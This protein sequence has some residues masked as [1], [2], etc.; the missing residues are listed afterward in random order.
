MHLFVERSS[1]I[2]R[3]SVMT[4]PSRYTSSVRFDVGTPGGDAVVGGSLTSSRNSLSA[5]TSPLSPGPKQITCYVSSPDN[6]DDNTPGLISK[7]SPVEYSQQ[8]QN[9]VP[10]MCRAV[11]VPAILQRD[12]DVE[13]SRSSSDS[14]GRL[15]RLCSSN[16]IKLTLFQPTREYNVNH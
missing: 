15:Q 1:L 14:E 10:R 2:G 12:L 13:S 4:S 6:I 3:R 11:S 9:V 16:V 8:Q 7:L 5:V